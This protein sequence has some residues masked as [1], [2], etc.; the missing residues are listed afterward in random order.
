[1]SA[2]LSYRPAD[3]TSA[4]YAI[5]TGLQNPPYKLGTRYK[6][7]D[8]GREYVFAK[9]TIGGTNANT[10]IAGRP[11]WWDVQ[12][13]FKAKTDN[14]G[15]EGV[16]A[17]TL[18]NTVTSGNATWIQ[19]PMSDTDANLLVTSGA[20]AKSNLQPD[21]ATGTYIVT[22]TTSAATAAGAGKHTVAVNKAAGSN[23]AT[24][25]TTLCAWR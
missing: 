17:G 19:T 22:D 16:H 25:A 14:A 7:R 15:T 3:L 6:D 4:D 20:T 13:S 23:P 2:Y 18:L 21:S 1:M 5:G 9:V 24:P 10:L 12:A 8:T 11:V